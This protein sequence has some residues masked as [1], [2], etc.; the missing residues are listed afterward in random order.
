MLSDELIEILVKE[1]KSSVVIHE[2]GARYNDIMR[3]REKIRNQIYERNK[4]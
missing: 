1:G 4:A 2:K 3:V